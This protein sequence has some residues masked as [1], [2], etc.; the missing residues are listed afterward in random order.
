MDCGLVS[1]FVRVFFCKMNLRNGIHLRG[2]SG[3][4]SVVSRGQNRLFKVGRE[5]A[6][7]PF[8]L[9]IDLFNISQTQDWSL[10]KVR[11]SEII[12]PL[13]QDFYLR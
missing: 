9:G 8:I 13:G 4:N 5:E 11:N 3:C 10:E 2:G 12:F 1:Q 6:L 7:L